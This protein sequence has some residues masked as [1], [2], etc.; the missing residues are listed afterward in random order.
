MARELLLKIRGDASGVEQATRRAKE[1][2]SGLGDSGSKAGGKLTSGFKGVGGAIGGVMKVAGP[3]AAV[4]GAMEIGNFF[5]DAVSG[6]RESQVEMRKTEAIIKATGGSAGVTAQQVADLAGEISKKTGIDD[7]AIQSSASLLLTFKKVRNEVGAGND[8]FNRA[9][10]AAQDMAAAGFGDADGAAKMLGKALN[11]PIK[12]ITALGR[13][14]VTF[15]EAQKKQIVAM[16][17]SG[18]LLGAQ[19]MIMKEVESQVG[20]T[21]EAMA[22]DTQKAQVAWGNL[23]EKLGEKFLIPAIDFVSKGM[24]DHVIPALESGVEWVEKFVSGGTEGMPQWLVD[25]RTAFGEV[26]TFLDGFGKG[27]GPGSGLLDWWNN[28]MLPALQGIGK[29]FEDTKARVMPI[30]EEIAGFLVEKYEE[31][32]PQITEAVE[33]VGGIVTGALGFIQTYIDQWGKEVEKFWNEWGWL[34]MSVIGATF[35]WVVEF[36]GGI[37]KVIQGVITTVTGLISGDWDKTWKGIQQIFA[38]VWKMIEAGINAGI[39]FVSEIFAKF[40][41]DVPGSLGEIVSWVTTNWSKIEAILTGPIREG[42][43]AINGWL[44]QMKSGFDWVVGKISAKFGELKNAA[45]EPVNFVIN[46]VYNNGLRKAFNQLAETLKLSFRLPELPGL[47]GGGILPGY[48]PYGAG[49]D[50][51]VALRSGEGVYVSEAMRDPYE[52]RRL[53]EVN[54]RALSGRPLR[55]LQLPGFEGGGI[56]RPVPGGWTTYSG[57][58]GIDFPVPAGTPVRA[59]RPGRVFTAAP[60]STWGNYMRVDHGGG[61]WSGY[62]HLRRFLAAVGQVVA[63]GQ[64]IALSGG[65]PGEPGAGNTTGAHLHW[66]IY[67]NG[68]RVFPGG[69]LTG[70][71]ALPGGAGHTKGT[72]TGPQFYD[73]AQMIK[74]ALGGPLKQLTSLGDS[75]IAQIAASFPKWLFDSAVEAG[76]KLLGLGGDSPLPVLNRDTGGWIPTGPSIVRNG[77]G[78]PEYMLNPDQVDQLLARGG[79]QVTVVVTPDYRG[80]RDLIRAE[81]TDRGPAPQGGVAS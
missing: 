37:L 13:A 58:N 63:G 56:Y 5:A 69:Y 27:G 35:G 51:L 32:E 36:I 16:T 23:Q 68:T 55:D 20:G 60:I 17:K 70:A 72:D 59:W 21:A 44:G 71:V 4:F 49:D 54:R 81:I 1:S 52:R 24:T 6:A 76:A 15:T 80:F 33:T 50:Q 7:E 65:V 67:R 38:G 74:D 11:D 73:P 26:G 79:G 34:I 41:I 2:V 61:L 19:K 48:R 22:T 53:Y 10:K 78:R 66:E 57:H 12:G 43:Q 28:D 25:V 18:D 14:G 9:T 64:T 3:L 40:G 47:A 75:P 46:T 30:I 29:A 31:Y 45:K 62:A 39:K 42:W 77:T 8:V